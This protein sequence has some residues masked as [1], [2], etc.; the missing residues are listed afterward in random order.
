MNKLFGLLLLLCLMPGLV[1]WSF[2]GEVPAPSG[3]GNECD[4]YD[5]VCQNFE[6]ATTGYD[7]SETWTDSN[8]DP[9]STTVILRGTQSIEMDS[10]GARPSAMTSF[11]ATSEIWGHFLVNNSAGDVFSFWDTNSKGEE[12]VAVGYN[13]SN[14][15]W[16]CSVGTIIAYGNYDVGTG[17]HHLWVHIDLVAGEVEIYGGTTTT[18]PG[19]AFLTLT[20]GDNTATTSAAVELRGEAWLSGLYSYID[21]I[22]INSSSFTTVD[23]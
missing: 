5:L 20:G 17:N 21:Q 14:G 6:T 18:R 2:I 23:N 3:G 7:N 1:G 4:N 8:A 19:S 9:A 11:T 22:L 10:A 16:S 12:L 13:T 15:N